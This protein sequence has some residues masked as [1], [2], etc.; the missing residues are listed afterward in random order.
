MS[1]PTSSNPGSNA[2]PASQT[3]RPGSNNL[4][5][6]Q[7]PHSAHPQ[8]QHGALG[9]AAPHSGSSSG[10]S[11]NGGGYGAYNAHG[12]VGTNHSHGNTPLGTPN[13]GQQHEMLEGEGSSGYIS[14]PSIPA[15]PAPSSGG[16]SGTG[17]T[18]N[19]GG[20]SN[21]GGGN[22]AS[23]LIASHRAAGGSEPIKDFNIPP[24]VPCYKVLPVIAKKH[25][26]RSDKVELVVCYDDQERMIGLEELPLKIFK[27]LDAKGKNPIFMIRESTGVKTNEGFVVSGTP[28]GLF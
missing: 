1:V 8:Q 16:S 26:V 12:G 24:D 13:L 23:N 14:T 25:K 15:T 28:G 2:S 9:M 18:S 21:G 4:G 20:S 11:S 19:G 10:N 6:V 7:S 27:E 5:Y 17:N 3:P 22:S